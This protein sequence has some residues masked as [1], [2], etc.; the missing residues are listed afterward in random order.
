MDK[1]H[2]D[3]R[4]DSPLAMAITAMPRGYRYLLAFA[5]GWRW[6]VSRRVLPS[7]QFRRWADQCVVFRI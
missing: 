6:Q 2:A 4:K 7:L 5:P 3:I 1:D